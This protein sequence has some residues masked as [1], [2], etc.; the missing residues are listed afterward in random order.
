[1]FRTHA[2]A[3]VVPAAV[4]DG[5]GLVALVDVV[6]TAGT[7]PVLVAGGVMVVVGAMAAVEEEAG[8]V[9]A[10]AAAVV[11]AP[12]VG[13]GAAVV[14]ALRQGAPSGNRL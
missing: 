14:V 12:E 13:V 11:D 6:D 4:V 9:L 7:V 10:E 3:G 2:A 1:M 8:R 5:D